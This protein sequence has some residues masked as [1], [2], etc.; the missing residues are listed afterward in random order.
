MDTFDHGEQ[1]KNNKMNYFVRN[2]SLAAKITFILIDCRESESESES[3]L[4]L[5]GIESL[6]KK[7]YTQ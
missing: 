4:Y 3:E 7:M 1:V 6:T 5:S 2:S